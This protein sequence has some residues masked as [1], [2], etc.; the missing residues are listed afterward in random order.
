LWLPYVQV[1]D[2]DA[3]IARATSKG[4]RVMNGPMEVPGGARIAQLTDPQGAAFA[5]HKAPKDARA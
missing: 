2:L 4:A 5:L 3:A 1:A